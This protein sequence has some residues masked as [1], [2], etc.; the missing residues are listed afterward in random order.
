MPAGDRLPTPGCLR[1]GQRIRRFGG[2]VALGDEAR[3]LVGELLV[4]EDCR[5]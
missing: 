4:L 1:H 3:I 5:S 2:G